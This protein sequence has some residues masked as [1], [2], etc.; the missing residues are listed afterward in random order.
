MK[1][2][3]IAI[4]TLALIGTGVV[5]AFSANAGRRACQ[6]QRAEQCMACAD[7][8]APTVTITGTVQA[9]SIPET[10]QPGPELLTVS[11]G[12]ESYQVIVG[13]VRVLPTLKLSVKSGDQVTIIGWTITCQDKPFVVVRE[14]TL[15]GKTYF[16]RDMSAKPLWNGKYC[17]GISCDSTNCEKSC[18]VRASTACP[19][20]TCKECPVT[21]TSRSP[22]ASQ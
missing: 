12:K 15:A 9:I 22:G 14:L 8:K 10:G 11:S 21:T 6:R 17:S 4:L 1:N 2:V 19:A 13:P 3:L 20:R 18:P 5:I 7:A 16:L